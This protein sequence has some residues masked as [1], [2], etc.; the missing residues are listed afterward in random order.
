LTE[1]TS[2]PIDHERRLR[3]ALAPLNAAGFVTAFGAHS[4]ASGLGVEDH[5]LGFSLLSFGLLLAVYDIA[6]V[7]LK[8]VFGT[9][10]D[11]IGL[12]PVIVGGLIGFALMSLAGIFATNILLVGIARFG[13]GAAASAFS[14]A[15]SAAVARSSGSGSVGRYF[16]RYGSWKSVGYAIG[17]LIA[18]GVIG[19][20][21]LSGLFVVL[22]G[23]AALVAVW[24]IVGVPALAVLPRQRYTVADL[25]G[26]LTDRGFLIPV[27]ALAI[28]TGALGAAVG[29]LPLVGARIGLGVFGSIA[30][31]SVMAVFSA[32]VQPLTGRLRD[33]GALRPQD[34]LT[35][36]IALIA[37][38]M[39]A[40]ALFPN[41]IV[42]YVVAVL[43]GT[44]IG[45]VTTLGFSVLA[46]TS[47]A[48]RMGRTMGTAELGREIGD[49]GGPLLIGG[50]ATGAGLAAGL[51]A[52]A[53][54]AALAAVVVGVFTPKPADPR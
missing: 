32:V 31:V 40:V 28:A 15:A 20:A 54:V 52:F 43:L 9:L 36:G 39:V 48:S 50:I 22:A 14:P 35:L 7:I 33:S 19:S 53:G 38:G 42:L 45:A 27:L 47:P 24:V 6:E 17:P 5:S 29:F 16:G 11:R 26:Q 10:S 51:A 4:V 25:V 49:A 13:Q 2:G 41:P 37:V 21:G 1:P 18:A 3:R 23:S 46:A 34:G 30:V 8:P 12:K 44:G